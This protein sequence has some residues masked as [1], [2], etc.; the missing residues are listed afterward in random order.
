MLTK[1]LD[2]ENDRTLTFLR[3]ALAVVMFPHGA[4]KVVGWFGGPGFAG[5]MDMFTQTMGIVAPLAFLAIVVEFFGSIALALG[6]LGRVA[7][8][9]MIVEM[10]VAVALVHL[11][12]G[13][14]MNWTGQQ[15]GE[16]FEYHIL[17]IALAFAVL[18]K[19]AGA[20]SIDHVLARRLAAG[21]P[22]AD[23]PDHLRDAHAH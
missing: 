3:W 18:V 14:F 11:P 4:Q 21:R 9:G 1:L 19:G 23:R 12:Y 13:F 10:L 22:A 6:L 16:G 8:L 2:T 15:A 7:A 5:A 17:F 20:W